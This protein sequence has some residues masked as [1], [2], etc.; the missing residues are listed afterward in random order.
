M[1]ADSREL[2]LTISELVRRGQ[3]F[4]ATSS[5]G[6]S[7]AG[8]SV[9][10][11]SSVGKLDNENPRPK[12]PP[13]LRKPLLN[14]T[15]TNPS[16]KVLEPL[17]RAAILIGSI[18]LPPE[19]LQCPH[20][21]CFQF[22]DDS[23]ASVCCDVLDFR[24]QLVGRRI[25]VLAWNFLPLRHG[26]GGFLEI[27]RWDFLESGCVLSRCT[28]VDPIPLISSLP[29][30]PP[31]PPPPQEGK[32]KAC[33]SI[34][35][36]VESVS[37]VSDVPCSTGTLKA[38]KLRG[39]IA[40]IMVCLCQLCSCKEVTKVL[41]NVAKKEDHRFTEA[42]F[43]YFVGASSCWHPVIM[44][45]VGSVIMLSG[46]KKKLVFIGEKESQLMFVTTENSTL[47]LPK[48]YR[49]W[50][51][52]P[53]TSIKGRGERGVYSGIIRGIYMQGMV[54]ELDK[55][56]WLLLT[57][58]FLTLPHSLRVGA[59]ISVKNAHFV[60]PKFHWTKMLILGTCI[61]SNISVESFSPLDTRCLMVSQS[62]S[63]LGIF[64]ESLRFSVKLWALVTV[65]CFQKK[66]AG[67]LSEKE[68]VGS[69][70][71][72]VFSELCTH[73]ANGC[74]SQPYIEN[75]KLV[76]PISILLHNCE[77]LWTE[78]QF[79]LENNHH[80]SSGSSHSSLFPDQMPSCQPLR[81]VFSS[82]EIGF[83]LLG[84]LKISSA[85]GRLQLV[86][87]T[88]SIDAIVPDLPSTW[89]INTIYKVVNFSIIV[90]GKPNS[91]CQSELLHH[92]SISCRHIFHLTPSARETNLSVY[93]YFCLRNAGC[94][95][96]PFYHSLCSSDSS[97]ELQSGN[98]HV[99][100]VTH[101]YPLVQKFQGVPVISD[102]CTAFAE[103]IV[104]SWELFLSGKDGNRHSSKLSNNEM[105]ACS[106]HGGY[107]NKKYKSDATSGH[108][109]VSLPADNPRYF[110]NEQNCYSSSVSDSTNS[111]CSNLISPEIFCSAT[112]RT[113]SS[114]NLDVLGKF[115]TQCNV[116]NR[117]NH[118]PR[119]QKMLL[120]FDST[121]NFKY[122]LLQI[123]VFYIIKHH[124]EDCLCASKGCNKF[125]SGKVL[126]NSNIHL[127]SLSF[128][129]DEGF[130]N[131]KLSKYPS[132]RDGT[133][134]NGDS[135]AGDDIELL[136]R[137]KNF[138][139]PEIC[140]DVCLYLPA[141]VICV[142]E[143]KHKESIRLLSVPFDKDENLGDMS[144]IFHVG[145]LISISGCVISIHG[146]DCDCPHLNSGNEMTDG[147]P[148]ARAFQGI[149]SSVHMLVLVDDQMVC[150]IGSVSR[151][152][153]PVGF[154][155]G[156]TASFYRVLK[157]R[158][159]NR[160][161][162]TPISF[163]VVNS[164]R[165]APELDA[166]KA[167]N[168]TLVTKA[169][170]VD[171]SAS[172]PLV[173]K[174]FSTSSLNNVTFGMLSELHQ[175]LDSKPMRFNCRVVSIHV[176][177]LEK[178][179]KRDSLNSNVHSV[180]HFLDIPLAGFLLDD[181][182]SSCF[183]WASG[184]RAATLLRLHEELSLRALGGYSLK[185]MA[186][187]NGPFRSIMHH[188][189]RIIN[190]HN[191]VTIKNCGPPADS[192]YQDLTVS[193]SSGSTLSAFD[194]YFLKFIAFNSCFG[195][196]LAVVGS[197]MDANTVVELE[198]E[199]LK[200]TGTTIPAG[201][202]MWASEI[203]FP[204]TLTNARRMMQELLDS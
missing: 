158:G 164:I 115:C 131:N 60:N 62:Q 105:N 147:I 86:D 58:H 95:N 133:S 132:P 118:E 176:L 200:H 123:G 25:R 29:S 181:G 43:V 120:E 172:N 10:H 16:P 110:G 90:E 202:N 56:V 53:E 167:A 52:F 21:S 156:V 96:G 173:T 148:Q 93:A 3:A 179:R 168:N 72:G 175:F 191:R 19:S 171:E 75:L 13:P 138:S 49:K 59:V 8:A 155:P 107:P 12:P 195:S 15:G 32:S 61:K 166:D 157:S 103:A 73:C 6:S 89:N 22:S 139:S 41:Q 100:L 91:P 18:T 152:S 122:Q 74:G 189:E 99:L 36:P 137:N 121:N 24:V 39:F 87:A 97:K 197:L 33:Y 136:L 63:Q 70:N 83:F 79:Q 188:L 35:G 149:K 98:F 68:I 94:Q 146:L 2:V 184:Q 57:D 14:P 92:R 17:N 66:F 108:S 109:D 124:A 150:I 128:S 48:L 64:I 76:V 142:L 163:I 50:L 84:N 38:Q 126:V 7:P 117:V 1:E 190:K 113:A 182:S 42:K 145:R 77:V 114:Y 185:W 78:S 81:R 28:N 177:V 159:S 69:K 47:Q 198:T 204:D 106:Q 162:L 45:L 203:C 144:G 11:S 54:M 46:L 125:S 140:A 186:M 9:C 178:R 194:E 169:F 192:C 174:N 82:E 30:A 187:G 4:T 67:T 102:G 44:K 201:Q 196:I 134:C 119:T 31:P 88:G 153:Y 23:S 161:M 141:S 170:T 135:Q 183:C 165:V 160:L 5:L 85:S 101:K 143:A 193:V 80:T 130:P 151:Q 20:R 71:H 26:N 55:E 34:H 65:A 116:K 104:L 199:Q 154:G 40:R 111:T 127:W 37:P 51:L 27:V 180:A 112:I 129:A